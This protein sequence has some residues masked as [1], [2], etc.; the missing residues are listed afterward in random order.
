LRF[1]ADVA[2]GRR[3]EDGVTYGGDLYAAWQARLQQEH[4]CP[5][6]G[7]WDWRC[8]ERTA[9]RAR[10]GQTSAAQF[11]SRAGALLPRLVGNCALA[12]AEEAYSAMAEALAP[13]AAP[14]AITD[15]WQEPETR[16]RYA[17]DVAKVGA[18]H[19]EAARNLALLACRL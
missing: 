12:A 17:E 10:A 6:C 15:R 8:A 11:L 3:Q 19:R 2:C 18:L 14:G 4:F 7:S 9:R 13:Y 16:A 5:D 1:A